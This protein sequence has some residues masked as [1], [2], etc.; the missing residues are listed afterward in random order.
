MSCS[1]YGCSNIMCD[2][3][4]L[5]IG[6]VCTN[7]QDEFKSYLYKNSIQVNNDDQIEQA[8][9]EFMETNKEYTPENPQRLVDEFFTKH[10]N[11]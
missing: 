4:V 2:T 1:R 5:G 10:T 8:L 6:Y 9:K 3:Y 11:L 7:C